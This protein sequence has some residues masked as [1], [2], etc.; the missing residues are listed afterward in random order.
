MCL[1]LVDSFL[2]KCT[3][4][5]VSLFQ[6]LG[7][8]KARQREKMAHV[9]EEFA[10][11]QDEADN[12]DS[13]LHSFFVQQKLSF[14]HYGCFGSW[15]LNHNLA[16]MSQFLLSG[17]ELEL[18]A[19]YECHYIYWYLCEII[20]NWQMSTLNRVD[21]FIMTNEINFLPKNAKKPKKKTSI[22]EKEI[23]L[24]TAD[25]HMFSAFYQV[26]EFNKNLLDLKILN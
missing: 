19:K 23:L 11:F 20:L 25:R 4:A 18:F 21:N 15:I 17:F 2:I 24:K 12:L 16:L 1:Q 7:Q 22:F 3:P 8:N 13:I 9:F 6:I 14:V 26:C 10:S 5:F